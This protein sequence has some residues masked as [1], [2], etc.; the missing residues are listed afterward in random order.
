VLAELL[1]VLKPGGALRIAVPDL[2]RA[3]RA[4]LGGDHAYFY[5]PDE[6]ARTAAAKLV[7]QIVWYGS[8]QTPMTFGFLEE[9]LSDARFTG[10]ARRAFGASA[11][12]GMADLDNRERES[13]FVEATKP[14]CRAAAA[15]SPG[16]PD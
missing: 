9:W 4:Y 5:V 3:I 8:V 2:D 7:T 15:A 14:Q 16:S 1:R 12:P 13:L 10:I 11:W 6:D